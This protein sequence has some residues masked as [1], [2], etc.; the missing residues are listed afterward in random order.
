MHA[1]GMIDKAAEENAK[2]PVSVKH[3]MAQSIE[4]SETQP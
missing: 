3:S 1:L 2:V 4:K